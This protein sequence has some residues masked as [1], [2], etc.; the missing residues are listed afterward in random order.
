[1]LKL[2]TQSENKYYI[3]RKEAMSVYVDKLRTVIPKGAQAQKAGKRW[4]KKWC[5]LWADN[6]YELLDFAKKIGLKKEWLQSHALIEHFDLVPSFREK[7]I[8]KGAKEL[9]FKEYMYQK[10]KEGK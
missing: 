1:M 4:S 3:S 6:L 7:A 10:R 8:K 2:K 9:S 5:H